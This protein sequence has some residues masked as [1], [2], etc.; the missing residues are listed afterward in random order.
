MFYHLYIENVYGGGLKAETGTTNVNLYYGRVDNLFGGGSEAGATTT[1]VGLGNGTANK[2]FGGSNISGDV[3]DSYV[4]ICCCIY[5]ILLI[6]IFQFAALTLRPLR[7]DLLTAIVVHF[8]GFHS[9]YQYMIIFC[10][11]LLFIYY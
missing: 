1:N 7:R 8:F 11:A 4:S 2:V 5:Y 9:Y 10:Y 3:N 6:F